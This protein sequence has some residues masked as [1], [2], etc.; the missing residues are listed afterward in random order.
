[1]LDASETWQQKQ[2]PRLQEE[3]NLAALAE[4]N[5][6]NIYDIMTKLNL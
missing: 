3:W 4:T 2:E 1:M 6:T 5:E